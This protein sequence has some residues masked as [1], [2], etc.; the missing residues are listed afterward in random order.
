L[1]GLLDLLQQDIPDRTDHLL[2]L[3]RLPGIYVP[4][5]YRPAYGPAGVTYQR[6]AAVPQQVRRQYL[7]DL[8]RSASRSFIQTGQTEF[9]HMALIEVSR[10]CSRGCR[11]CAAGFVYLP[12]RERSLDNLLTQ[13]E[14]GLCQ[15]NRIGLV[16]AAVADYSQF[17]ALEQGILQRQGEI[18]VASLRLDAIDAAGVAILRQAGHSSVAIAP[19]AGSQR[20]RDYINKGLGEEQIINA[21]NILADGGIRHLKLYFLI[22]LPGEDLFDMEEIVRLTRAITMIWRAAGQQAGQVGHVTVSVNPFIPKPFT[23]L[24]W[25]GMDGE[26]ALKKKGR[27]LQSACAQLPNTRFMMESVRLAVL[28]AFLSRGD[29]RCGAL[30]PELAQGGNLRQLCAR[31]GGS[32]A[33]IVTRTRDRNESFPWEII[34]QGVAREYL[35]REFQGAARHRLTPPCAPECRRCGLCG[36]SA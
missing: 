35:W 1:D 11:F 23:P 2:A 18:S 32:L 8:D 20:L 17:T 19:E 13:V 27:F 28:Q 26:K 14:A 24:Q 25:A 31:T 36:G 7:A 33:D 29:R 6:T 30:L 21:V 12:P 16:A 34:D 22:G 4:R 9:G 15:R 3:A 5:F 10:G